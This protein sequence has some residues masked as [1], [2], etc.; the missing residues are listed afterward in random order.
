MT[1]YQIM[2]WYDIPVQVRA[3]GRRD[4]AG[5]ELPA[6]FQVAVDNAAMTAGLTGTDAYLAGFR[7]GEPEERDGTPAEVV[8]AVAAELDARYAQID[9]K[10]TVAQI[11]SQSADES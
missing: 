8:A 11:A 1:S 6:R 10:K 3:G 4:R 5:M 2:Y 7:W 9:W